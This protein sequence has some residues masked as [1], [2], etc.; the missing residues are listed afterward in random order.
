MTSH[1]DEPVPCILCQ[2]RAADDQLMRVEVWQDDLWRLTTAYASET[3]G[4]SYLE[5]RRHIT[6]MTQL[7]GAEAATFGPTLARVT[8]ALREET[9]AERVYIYVFG[10]SVP[11]LHLH[12]APH[13]T[14]DALNDQMIRGEL[15]TEK[16][17]SGLELIAS[18]DFPPLPEAALRAL[19]ERLR[20]RLA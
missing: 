19:A 18:K 1:P 12:L 10:D 2:G 20:A 17:P 3:P 11:H 6:D 7:D 8:S 5:P 4:F 16:L 9:G 15:V 14:G 13:T